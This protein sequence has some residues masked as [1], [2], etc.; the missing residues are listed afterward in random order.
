M[1]DTM[2][3][4]KV[5]G[6]LPVNEEECALLF[7]GDVPDDVRLPPQLGGTVVKVVGS[8]FA[9]CPKNPGYKCRHLA[10]ENGLCVAESV[11]D[12]QFYWY[13]KRG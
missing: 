11:K 8:F 1:G 12:G 4:N 2:R 10:L 9:D 6:G 5:P 13:R 7:G 3:F